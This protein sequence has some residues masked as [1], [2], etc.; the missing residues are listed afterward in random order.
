MTAAMNF[1][2]R[3]SDNDGEVLLRDGDDQGLRTTRTRKKETK[4]PVKCNL[5]PSK[6]YSW[7]KAQLS[8][9]LF[10]FGFIGVTNCKVKLKK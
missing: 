9:Q 2:L 4:P 1:R 10:L 5:G 7:S 6:C 3:R 8:T